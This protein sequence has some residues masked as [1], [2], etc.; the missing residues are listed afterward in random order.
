MTY[1][2]NLSSDHYT[3]SKA[4]FVKIL[5]LSLLF[6]PL[7][8]FRILS[9]QKQKT[10][11]NQQSQNL[12]SQFWIQ[13]PYLTFFFC[14][15]PPDLAGFEDGGGAF[16]FLGAYQKNKKNRYKIINQIAIMNVKSIVPQILYGFTSRLVSEPKICEKNN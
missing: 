13:K 10:Q 12:Q 6:T 2:Y 9:N 3:K 11:P 14:F 4:P 15:P 16:S 1:S 8:N 7:C 5:V